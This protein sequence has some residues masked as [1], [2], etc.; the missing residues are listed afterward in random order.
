MKVGSKM[1]L[2]TKHIPYSFRKTYN[3]LVNFIYLVCIRIWNFAF[4]IPVH[5]N[6]K[7]KVY[8]VVL[9]LGLNDGNTFFRYEAY[10]C[11]KSSGNLNEYTNKITQL[12]QV[13]N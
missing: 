12:N 8:N 3:S 10:T 11:L 5:L 7:G 1:L 6:R 2:Y 4:Y 13:Q 9:K